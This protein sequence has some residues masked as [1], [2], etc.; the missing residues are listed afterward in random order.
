MTQSQTSAIAHPSAPRHTVGL[1]HDPAHVLPVIYGEVATLEHFGCQ[2]VV[3][4]DS[5][6]TFREISKISRAG[7]L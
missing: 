5:G 6:Q 7:I 2:S 4:S 3:L 1:P